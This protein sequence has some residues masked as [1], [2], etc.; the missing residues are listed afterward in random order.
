MKQLQPVL[1]SKGTFLTPQHM[2]LQD[3]F[4]ED[5]MNFRV[6]A[7]KF[8]AW[9]FTEL[10]LDQELLTQGQLAITRASGI[11]PDSLPFEIPGPDQPPPSKSIEEF[12]D[13]DV[14]NL[15][16]YLAIP[17]YKDKGLNVAGLGRAA[18]ARYLAEIANVRDDNT[19]AGEKPIQIARKNLRLLAENESREGSSVLRVANIEK[20]ET[21]VFRL[22]P[23][24]VPPLLEI[25]ASDYLR[26]IVNGILEILSAK[27]AQLSGWRRQK[28]QSL[29]DFTTADIANF[30]LLY[31]VNSNI[32]VLSH[33]LQGQRCHPQELFAAL[34]AL[35]ASLTTFSSTIRP[36]DL[37][38]YDHADLSKVY[39]EL[40][41]KLRVLLETVV[42]TNV[43]SLPLKV[44]SNTIYA[45]AVDQDKY[46]KN[47]R[48]YL[49]IGAD[50]SEETI[51]RRVPQLVKTCSATHIDQLVSSAL[52]GITLTHIPSPPSAIPI[53]MQ[54]QYFSLNQSGAAWET[55]LRA[56]NFAAHVPAEIANPQMELIILLPQTGGAS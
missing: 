32:P 47:T 5:S 16:F 23:R 11:F 36:R 38:L 40:D 44:V 10:V 14:R 31:T 24:F 33:L 56:R 37:P 28:N 52:P 18:N 53:K 19:G 20:A 2:Q 45:T 26:G 7:L 3:K 12:F 39:T 35:G 51:I 29:A 42:P 54:Y 43:V 46:L 21:G 27:S 4:L 13:P 30:W 6:Q 50:V 34:T 48:M 22:N 1:W 9:G 17:D 25:H 8:C 49:A 41:E 15:D 55:V